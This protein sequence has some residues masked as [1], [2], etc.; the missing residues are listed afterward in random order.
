MARGGKAA[1]A[2]PAKAT[3]IEDNKPPAV[4]VPGSDAP[5]RKIDSNTLVQLGQEFSDLFGRYAQDRRLV[6]LKWTRNLRQYLGIYDPEIEKEIGGQRSRAYPRVTRIKCISTLSR[7]MNLMYPGNEK[8]W[9]LTAS[10]SHD[11]DPKDVAQAVADMVQQRQAQGVAT[12]VTEDMLDY[13][14]QQLADKRADQLSTLIEGQLNE[15]GGNQTLDII[16]LDRKVAWSGILY[17]LGVLEGPYVRTVETQGWVSSVPAQPGGQITYKPIT[18]QV[19]KPQYDFCP[20]WDFYPDMSAKIL[21]QGDGYF[22]RKIMGKSQVRKLANRDGFFPDQVK[23]Y[24]SNNSQGNYKPREFEAEL[25][26]MGTKA[27]VNDSMKQDPQSKYEIIVWKGPVSARKLEQCGVQIPE[28]KLAD[29]IDAEI[30]MIDQTVIKADM[31]PWAKLGLEVK[32]VHT[33]SFDE[34]DTSPI[35]N[36]LPYVI[37]D[38]VMSIAAATRMTLDN[39]S[40]TCGPNIEVNTAFMQAGQDVSGIEAYK[41]WL[42]DDDG[43]TAQFPAVRKVD[44]DGH[45]AELESLIKLFMDFADAESFV[46]PATGG[47]MQQMPS[48]PMRTAAGA[49]MLRGEAALP[50]KDIIRNFDSYKQSMI[51]ALVAFNRKFNPDL[52]QPA[53]Y[54]VVARGATSLIAKEVRGIQLDQLATTLTPEERDHIDE[55]KF[56]EMRFAVR[57]MSSLL[58]PEEEAERKKQLREQQMAQAQDIATRLQVAQERQFLSQAFKNITQGQKNSAAADATSTQT[59]IGILEHGLPDGVNGDGTG[60]TPNNSKAGSQAPGNG[61]GA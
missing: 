10:S 56:V 28:D 20:V 26:S 45:L 54:N 24:L 44:I 47:D 41:I 42:R 50:F 13:A 22:L 4:P 33:F 34:D 14:I 58:V 5:V 8:N 15:I 35:A 55:R 19:R 48:E 29:D 46:G 25:R 30:W 61:A 2:E 6:E 32:T 49:S 1:P 38:S 39:A 31:N 57:D 21:G 11:M 9:E 43:P 59:A 27:H 7:I 60:T 17:G 36:G 3:Q 40:V 16:A 12:P 52:T 23:K 37:R 53:T 18:R 51:E